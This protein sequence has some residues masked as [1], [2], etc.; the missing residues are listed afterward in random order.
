[1]KYLIFSQSSGFSAVF[2]GLRTLC[3]FAAIAAIT[4]TAAALA[5]LTRRTLWIG[6]I[7]S[8]AAFSRRMDVHADGLLGRLVTKKLAIFARLILCVAA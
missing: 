2:T 7:T 4:V 1:M 3:A 8:C 6:L 5:W